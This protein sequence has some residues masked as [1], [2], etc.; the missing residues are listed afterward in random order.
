MGLDPQLLADF[1]NR[2][3]R[4]RDANPHAWDFSRRLIAQAGARSMLKRLASAV[5]ASSL[6]LPMRE[7]LLTG[8]RGGNAERIRDL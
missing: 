3:K 1:R 8:L 7:A 2:L 5:E 4:S 6:P